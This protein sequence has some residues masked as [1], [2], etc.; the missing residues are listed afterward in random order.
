MRLL[1]VQHRDGD[2][3]VNST[4]E[5]LGITTA[6]QNTLA[7]F[8]TQP[9]AAAYITAMCGLIHMG[10]DPADFRIVPVEHDGVGIAHM[11]EPQ[12]DPPDDGERLA[13]EECGESYNV[14]ESDAQD[15]ESFC[16]RACERKGA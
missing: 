2:Q 6:E 1:L 11:D 10:G 5:D 9:E 14:A 12:A 8:Y 7:L 15:P 13:C 4:R 3:W 16:S